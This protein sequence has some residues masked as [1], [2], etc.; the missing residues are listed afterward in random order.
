MY[1]RILVS[2]CWFYFF[3]WIITGVEINAQ[4]APYDLTYFRVPVDHPIVLAGSFAELRSSHFHAGID[5]KPQSSTSTDTI[6]LSANGY[7]SRIKI[8]TGGYGKCLY[9]DHPNGY[10]TVYAHLKIFNDTIEQ[11]IRQLQKQS[12]SYTLDI[13]PDSTKFQFAKGDYIGLMGNTGRSYGKHLHFEIRETLSEV[14]VNPA[15]FGIKPPDNIR[16]IVTAIDLHRLTPDMQC[17]DTHTYYPEAAGNGI[18][19]IGNGK[20]R[21]P[22]WQCGLGVQ[23]FDRMDG[24]NNRNG[25]YYQKVYVDDTLYYSYVLNKVGWE[26]TKYIHS[27]VDYPTRKKDRRTVVRC[28]RLPG[29]KLTI[30]DS[31]RNEGVIRLF[32]EKPRRI[33]IVLGDVENNESTIYFSLYRD[34]IESGKS[35]PTFNMKV[36]MNEAQFFKV[37][38]WTVNIPA[39]ASDRDLFLSYNT[40][41]DDTE[42]TIYQIGSMD[43]ILFSAATITIPL[44]EIHDSLR[45]KSVVLQ[46]DGE[47]WNCAGGMVTKDTIILMSNTLGKFR[48]GIDTIAPTVIPAGT[49]QSF[50]KGKTYTYLLDDNYS[51]PEY[52]V[53]ID[54]KWIIA[55]YKVL[56]KRLSVIIPEDLASGNHKLEIYAK[57][58]RKNEIVFTKEI[59]VIP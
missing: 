26:E 31:L 53:Y 20:L 56:N 23:A 3:F 29:N 34:D 52:D 46:A 21:F 22:A 33:K 16:P 1:K 14:P 40:S 32:K 24:A 41:E 45:S 19:K 17:T 51:E 27:H 6:K 58:H 57:D 55:P 49:Y 13:Y 7:I 36:N 50:N 54:G 2:K 15:L 11:Y 43:H 48:L 4:Y 30:Y 59:N 37:G 25:I 9:F 8:Q 39:F 5:I 38:D 35:G 47:E 10:T 42:N 12:E 44:T 18:Y 28:Y